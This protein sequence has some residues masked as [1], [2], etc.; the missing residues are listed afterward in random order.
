MRRSEPDTDEIVIAP[1]H[2]DLEIPEPRSSRVRVDVAGRS[3]TG[4]VRPNNED[5]FL[6]CRLGRYLEPLISSLPQGPSPRRQEHTAHLLAVADG[7]GG[8]AAG[9]VASS[10]ALRTAF[11]LVL[12]AVKWALVVE[13]PE[14]REQ[15]IQES[16]D[17]AVGYLRRIDEILSDR[18]RAEPALSG[19]G[20]TLTAAYAVGDQMYLVHVGDSRAYLFRDG[21]LRRLTRDQTVAQD[22]VDTGRLA[23]EEL[24]GHRLGHVLTQALGRRG[25][26][27]RVEVHRLEL[28]DQDRVVLCTDGLTDMVDDPSV[29][30]TLAR[31]PG[32]EAACEAL[33]ELALAR[34]GRDNV[35]VV[36]AGFSIP[37]RDSEADPGVRVDDPGIDS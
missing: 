1:E 2:W 14:S 22:L 34:G 32:S 30:D 7:M 12:G 33:T 23:P 35:T 26:E 10:M 21:A 5:A 8:A 6:V 27:V 13:R 3:H 19:M 9:E 24:P 31:I 17:R 11:Q 20:T 25:G 4:R 18:A 29:Q 37:P 16:T 15:E 28:A 36:V